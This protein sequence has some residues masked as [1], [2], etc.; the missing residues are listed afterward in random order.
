M[1]QPRPVM[2]D[3]SSLAR[4][5][6]EKC[7]IGNPFEGDTIKCTWD[8]ATRHRT[9]SS[10]ARSYRKHLPENPWDSGI[11]RPGG[12][13]RRALFHSSE[14]TDVRCNSSCS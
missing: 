14:W 7:R 5:Y 10:F 2:R 6:Q 3:A 1:P 13:V 4:S 12:R 9:A 11:A 8:A